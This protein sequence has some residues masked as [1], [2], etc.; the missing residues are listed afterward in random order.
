MY[1]NIIFATWCLNLE[2]SVWTQCDYNA[3]INRTI[4]FDRITHVYVC[5]VL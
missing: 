2:N 1:I 3:L 5:T 4:K